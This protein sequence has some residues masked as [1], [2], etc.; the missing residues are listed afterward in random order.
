MLIYIICTN[1][2]QRR[3]RAAVVFLVTSLLSTVTVS[4]KS[5]RVF[6]LLHRFIKDE[7]KLYWSPRGNSATAAFKKWISIREKERTQQEYKTERLKRYKTWHL[8][9]LFCKVEQKCSQVLIVVCQRETVC[10]LIF[11]HSQ[12]VQLLIH[13]W[14]IHSCIQP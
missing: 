6:A 10:G 5:L 1:K 3:F 9:H 14:E 4:F 13:L 11:C 12:L 2:N 8:R 7:M